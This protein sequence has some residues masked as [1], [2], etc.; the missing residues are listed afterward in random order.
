MADLGS[1]LMRTAAVKPGMAFASMPYI[2]SLSPQVFP[3]EDSAI[4]GEVTV[5]G[6]PTGS[7]RV[8]LLHSRTRT[9]VTTTR[10]AGDGTFSFSSVSPSE[11][12]LVVVDAPGASYNAQ[13][14]RV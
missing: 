12:Y 6:V 1:I 10:T 11:D 5:E 9:L 8:H 4:S 13:V 7:I 2:S 14:R 3:P